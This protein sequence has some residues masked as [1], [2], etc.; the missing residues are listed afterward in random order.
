MAKN[1][2]VVLDLGCNTVK[3]GFAGEEQP[4]VVARSYYS[5]YLDSSEQNTEAGMQTEF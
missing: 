3:F 4:R 2:S 5:A 1:A